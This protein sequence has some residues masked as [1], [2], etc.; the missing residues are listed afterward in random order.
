MKLLVGPVCAFTFARSA[1]ANVV[2][3]HL[4]A[5]D[6]ILQSDL[7]FSSPLLAEQIS[8][9]EWQ[10]ARSSTAGNAT[11]QGYEELSSDND[12]SADFGWTGPHACEGVYCVYTNSLFAGGRGIAIISDGHTANAL[13]NLPI[14]IDLSSSAAE[15]L[16]KTAKVNMQSQNVETRDIPGKGRGLVPTRPIHRGEQILAY[17]PVLVIHRAFVDDLSREQQLRLLR[18]AIHRLPTATRTVFWK[19]LGQTHEV[20]DDDILDIVMNNSFNLPLQLP[21]ETNSASFIGNFP[22]VS[23][24]NHDCRPNVAFHLESGLIHRTHAVRKSVPIQPGEELSISYVDSFRARDVRRARTK[25]NWGFEC[26]CA[27]CM[28]PSALVN[29]SDHRLWRIYEVETA[30]RLDMTVETVDHQKSSDQSMGDLDAVELLI[31]LYEQERLLESHGSST[32]QVAALYYNAHGR[33]ELAIKYALLALEAGIVEDG[34]RSRNVEEL[35]SLLENPESH[36]S[37]GRR[38]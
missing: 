18:D 24:Y 15:S 32:Y 5:T 11:R 26:T 31:S 25:Q 22:E 3:A 6:T 13:A 8:S 17:T 12:T 7:C 36:W 29:A 37:W 27:Q 10:C 23:M 19:Q 30:L 1:F 2:D 33:R 4:L 14:F 21:G 16:V 34:A 38:V 20:G 28:L 9:S 35:V